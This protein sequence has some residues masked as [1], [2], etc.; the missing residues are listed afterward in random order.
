[1]K[2]MRYSSQKF[3]RITQIEKLFMVSSEF[4]E[5]EKELI[6]SICYFMEVEKIM[7]NEML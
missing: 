4:Y 6:N 5:F 7:V 2:G 3:E 1:M